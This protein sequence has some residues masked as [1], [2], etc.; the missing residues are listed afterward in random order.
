LFDFSVHRAALAVATCCSVSLPALA[1]NP[2]IQT[3]FTAD[4]APMVHGDTVAIRQ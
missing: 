4:P 3:S 1:D 2:L